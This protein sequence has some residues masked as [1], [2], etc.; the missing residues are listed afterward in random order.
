MLMHTEYFAWGLKMTVIGMGLVFAM[1]GV[2]WALLTL[3]LA[4]DKP[5]EEEEES[6]ASA[7]EEVEA[8]EPASQ[9]AS[10]GLPADLVA[11][12]TAAVVKHKA[13]LLGGSSPIMRTTWS[14][15]QQSNWVIAGRARQTN[16]W[17]PRGK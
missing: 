11:A 3:I 4:L 12:I 8:D 6:S 7:S 2:L 13:A 9:P 14:G 10:A 15:S 16:T 5:E 1:L 17:T